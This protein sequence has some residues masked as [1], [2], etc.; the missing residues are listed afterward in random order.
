MSPETRPAVISA[1]NLFQLATR[2]QAGLRIMRNMLCYVNYL[3]RNTSRLIVV[4]LSLVLIGCTGAGRQEVYQSGAIE[5]QLMAE[6]AVRRGEYRIAA[7]EYVRV[8]QRSDDIEYA[9]RATEFAYEYGL[10]AHALTGA[11]RWVQLAPDSRVAHD[12]LGRLYVRRNALDPAFTSLDIAMGPVERRR[13]FEYAAMAA[14]LMEHAPA[15]RVEKIFA[16][17]AEQSP[18][19]PGILRTQ[20]SLAARAGD[21]DSAVEFAR[22]ATS[23]APAWPA[24]RIMLANTLL[25]AGDR[26]SAFEQ[27]AF[28]VEAGSGIDTELEFIRLL[29][30]AGDSAEALER[31]GRMED[32]YPADPA[33]VRVRATTHLNTGDLAAA[34][35]DYQQLVSNGF[36]VDESLW[37]MGRIAFEME[38]YPAAVN[39][40][41][42]IR[43]DPW[44]LPALFAQAGAYQR[45]GDLAAALVLLDDYVARYPEQLV[46]T[47]N[48]RAALLIAAEQPEQA[49]AALDLALDYRPWNIGL[50]LS[51]GDLLDDLGEYS[52]SIAA[53]RQAHALAPDN[54]LTLNALGYTLTNRS[55]RYAEAAGYITLAVEMVPDS[56]PILDSMG[57]LL[58]KRKQYDS[59]QTYL[60]RAYDLLPDPEIA[61]HLGELYWRQK[62]RAQAADVWADAA[63]RFPDNDVLKDTMRRFKQ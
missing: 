22:Q 32:R 4:L 43:S 59:A 56:A 58:L 14:V 30:A 5:S 8:A 37:Q 19:N 26:S 6:I 11:Q 28:A 2:L 18:D 33:L 1:L 60:E 44:R 9:R 21:T 13:E 29:N 45:Q 41:K 54:A 31:I 52:D 62:Q 49:L 46:D 24:A 35:N 50:W 53:F 20:A 47:L 48:T 38:E 55:K 61:A 34:L 27:M 10:D 25:A 39:Y 16:R 42:A 57:W 3:T 63:E 40:F 23:L 17:F 36:F 12:Y 15:Q 51:K 7:Q